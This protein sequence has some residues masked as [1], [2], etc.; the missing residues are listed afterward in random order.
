MIMYFK[1]IIE[2]NLETYYEHLRTRNRKRAMK[3]IRKLTTS[4]ICSGRDIVSIYIT[5]DIEKLNQSFIDDVMFKL[6]DDQRKKHYENVI[7]GIFK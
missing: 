4:L 2:T 6:T 5:R 7:E 3:K 1:V